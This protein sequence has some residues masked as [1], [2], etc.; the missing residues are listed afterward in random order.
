MN[1]VYIKYAVGL[2][3]FVAAI[4]FFIIIYK[5]VTLNNRKPD[6]L[7]NSKNK[8]LKTETVFKNEFGD[9]T[10]NCPF[11]AKDYNDLSDEQI[12]KIDP[13]IREYLSITSTTKDSCFDYYPLIKTFLEEDIYY[14]TLPILNIKNH[15][16]LFTVNIDFSTNNK[17]E[18]VRI[19][20]QFSGMTGESGRLWA[21]EVDAQEIVDLAKDE[22]VE[23][24]TIMPNHKMELID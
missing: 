2:L 15:N 11:V 6:N 10:E 9:M 14:A 19:N 18:L 21:R 7:I 22:K 1:K 17:T 3:I 5:S 24:I 8:I 23:S 12:K 4:S 16:L 13:R 20:G